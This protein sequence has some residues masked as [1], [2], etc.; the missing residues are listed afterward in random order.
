MS[1]RAYR[2]NK[3]DCNPVDSF[4]LWRHSAIVKWL[5]NRNYLSSLNEDGCGII[6]I[7][8]EALEQM[9]KEVKMDTETKKCIKKDIEYARER[10]DYSVMYYCF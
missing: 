4:N 1:V 6:E 10:N 5:E 8:V 2:I 3:I 9:L 7:P